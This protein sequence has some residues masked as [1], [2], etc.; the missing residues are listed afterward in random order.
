[1]E[2]I[3]IAAMASNRVIGKDGSIPW[4]IPEELQ[5]FKRV[6]MGYPLIMGRKTHESI[7]FVLPGRKNIVITRDKTLKIKGCTVVHSIDEAIAACDN[8]KRVFVLGG[9]DI[10][11]QT[12]KI[13][14]TILLTII[15]R[16]IEG[17]TIFPEFSTGEF[18]ETDS[19]RSEGSDPFTIY[20]YSRRG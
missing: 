10:F 9:E 20:T 17:D 6:T 5:H 11:K 2:I 15:D 7:G 12:L 13:A 18:H 1:M 3:L 8:A 4:H 19:K 14:D 16:A